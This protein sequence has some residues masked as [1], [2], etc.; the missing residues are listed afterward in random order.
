M[1]ILIGHTNN[2][3]SRSSSLKTEATGERVPNSAV[4]RRGTDCVFFLTFVCIAWPA[5]TAAG[6][7]ADGRLSATASADEAETFAAREML[8]R[9][10]EPLREGDQE[11]TAVA[12]VIRVAAVARRLRAGTEHDRA[13]VRIGRHPDND[14]VLL[15]NTTPFML[16]LYHATVT[17]S[18]GE[19]TIADSNSTNGTYVREPTRAPPAR[20]E[21]KRAT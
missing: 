17:Y 3:K 21:L 16:S 8:R 11:D 18:R 6:E 15:S 4:A 14:V 19:Y 1:H 5:G 7:R 10:V 9:V 12:P 2:P 20:C 13:V